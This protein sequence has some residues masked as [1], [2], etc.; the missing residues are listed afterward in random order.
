MAVSGAVAG[1]SAAAPRSTPPKNGMLIHAAS[2]DASAENSG[3]KTITLS[4]P[5]GTQTETI[6]V[7]L[8]G[9]D[10]SL[11]F[12]ETSCSGAV[13]ETGTLSSADGMRSGK[14]VLYATAKK[15]DGT[16]ASSRLRF[17]GDETPLA[18]PSAAASGRL[19]AQVT[20]AYPTA[21]NFLPPAV[22]FNTISP[23]GS[24]GGGPWIRI[25]TQQTYPDNG[26][27]C[28][29]VYTV[30]VLDR[31]TLTEKSAAPESSPQCFGDG[32]SMATYLG[33]LT[34]E[35]LVIA[36]S[37]F[38]AY[39]D[40]KLNTT[41]IGG[42]DF[43]NTKN[44]NNSNY[45]LGYI[46]I[47]A[48][49][50]TPGSAFENYYT[51]SE[52]TVDQFAT[53]MLVEDV[54]G[55]YNFQPSLAVEYLVAP[56]DQAN[57]N[58]STVTLFNV[59]SLSQYSQFS[60]PEKVVFYSPSSQSGGYWMLKLQRDNLN[61]DPNCGA[62]ANQAKQQTDVPA[63]GT[64]YATGSQSPATATKAYQSLAAALNAI[65]PDDLVFLVT[66]GQAGYSPNQS[67][68]DVAA[69]SFIDG[70]GTQQNA[71]YQEFA[72]A[73]ENVGGTPETTLSLYV[74]GSAYTLVTCRDCGNSL[75]GHAVLS[76]SGFTQ[77]GETGFVHG[78][79][80]RNLNGFYWPGQTSQESQSQSAAGGGADFT[81]SLVGSQQPV[82]WPELSGA[83]LSG[84]SS[85]AG[86]VAAY[87]YLSY[88][89]VTQYYIRGAQGNYLDD[90][91]YYFTGAN[92]TYID[93]H[94]FYPANLPFPGQPGSC[95]V[96]TDPVTNTALTCFTQQDLFA[97]AQQ[98]STEVVDLDNVLQ[99]MVNGSTNMK[100]TVATGNGSA[101]L[102]LI[103]QLRQWKA[104]ICSR[105]R[106]LR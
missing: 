52:Q 58:L 80:R 70:S 54:N 47:G 38:N 73:L 13:C 105:L 45:P 63:C 44:F 104:A 101:A 17:A 18:K 74:P 37:N 21:S 95:Y 85:V 20:P 2:K 42:T 36:G 61:I 59:G 12:S 6:K 82:E 96:W 89:L 25:G 78:L 16:L 71:F 62:I 43:T 23:G 48:G 66:V 5:A 24:N 72:P 28:S 34:S 19:S 90:I 83:P 29:T 10:V 53:G 22:A 51:S 93:Y 87:H 69:T 64:F 94:T 7:V 77:Q 14:N 4:L 76:A 91:H 49:G 97:V 92:N 106:L 33:T 65:A 57:S 27:S 8:N 60:Y 1:A 46:A 75:N 41:A 103:G 56:N 40:S 3:T 98:V 55:N 30:I 32:G 31:Q 100:D 99:F 15:S 35:D 68:W 26:Y 79:L 11:R 84:A 67:S 50:A 88:Q 81:M 86:Q 102:A 39:P 9:E